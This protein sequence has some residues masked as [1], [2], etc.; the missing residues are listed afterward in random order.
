MVSI[1]PFQLETSAPRCV[2]DLV[3]DGEA[4]SLAI[5]E[6]AHGHRG[7]VARRQTLDLPSLNRPVQFASNCSGC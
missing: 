5:K 2:E 3:L 4:M 7:K 6:G 1:E